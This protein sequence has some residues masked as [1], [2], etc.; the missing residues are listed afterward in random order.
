VGVSCVAKQV[1][2]DGSSF[3]RRSTRRKSGGAIIGH[4]GGA[5]PNKSQNGDWAE[6]TASH[7]G[8]S[9]SLPNLPDG[10]LDVR[11][12]AFCTT[13]WS[14]VLA[15]KDAQSPAAKEALEKLCRTYWYPLYAYVRR[16]GYH[17]HDADELTQEFFARLLARNYLSVADRHRGRFRSFLLGSLEHFLAREWTRRRAQKRGGGHAIFSLHCSDAETRYLLEPS[18]ELTPERIFDRRWATT[19]LDQALSKLRRE[20][21]DGGKG[22]L[23]AQVEKLLSG[24]PD[25][26]RYAEIAVALNMSVGAIKV[27]VHRLRQRYA[28]LVRAEIAQTVATPEEV[29]EELRYLFRAVCG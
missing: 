15:A 4:M 9:S 6:I 25:D 1:L 24:Q 26:A 20:S 21:I 7:R 23:F 16:K 27:A 3:A 17:P 11:H 2:N 28:E 14:L 19:L 22:N 13:H 10:Q 12:R 5:E 29:G 18:H 8:N